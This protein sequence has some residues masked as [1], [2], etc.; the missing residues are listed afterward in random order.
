MSV[1]D[2]GNAL[3]GILTVI[4]VGVPAL[5]ILLGFFAVIGGYTIQLVTGNVG[6]ENFGILL[7]AL[8][9]ILYLIELFLYYYSQQQR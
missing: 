4:A 8:G 3:R 1:E 2:I 6:M 9:V 7:I 5:L